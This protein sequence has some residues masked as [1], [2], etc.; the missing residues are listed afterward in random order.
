M[1]TKI[2]PSRASFKLFA[3][4]LPSSHHSEEETRKKCLRNLI[5]SYSKLAFVLRYINISRI[6][7]QIEIKIVRREKERKE[8]TAYVRVSTNKKE[9]FV[10][11]KLP[12]T[13][14]T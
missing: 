1:F 2:I 4:N 11:P 14:F 9:I 7:Q 13:P 10:E 5:S 6:F 12:F 3:Y 8:E